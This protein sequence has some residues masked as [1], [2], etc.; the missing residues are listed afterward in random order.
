MSKKAKPSLRQWIKT[1][2]WI[3]AGCAFFAVLLVSIDPSDPFN[4][5]VT[6]PALLKALASALLFWLLGYIVGDVVLKG[7][8]ESVTVEEIPAYEGG[9][10]QQV[11]DEK[12]RSDPE[13]L[14]TE[15]DQEEAQSKQREKGTRRGGPS[16]KA[17]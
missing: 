8:V 17:A 16:R 3:L 11:R 13:L 1:S 5:D 9:L 15:A 2:A 14:A 7:L 6:V 12:L 4:L 10:I